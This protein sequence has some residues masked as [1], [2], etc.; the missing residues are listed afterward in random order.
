MRVLFGHKQR[1]SRT[2]G[3]LDTQKTATG[4]KPGDTPQTPQPA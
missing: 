4:T 1:L 2:M 3:M